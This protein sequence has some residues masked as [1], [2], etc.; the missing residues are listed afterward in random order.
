VRTHD[1]IGHLPP[2]GD[3]DADLTVEL[4]GELGKLAGQFVGDDPR[5]RDAPPVELADA[6]EFR[7]PEAGDVSVNLFY[8]RSLWC[9]RF[10]Q[11]SS[12]AMLL[13]P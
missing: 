7:R 6:F 4:A 9:F 3:E 13:Q 11:T 12:M 5:R 8:G 10:P 2:A 1:D